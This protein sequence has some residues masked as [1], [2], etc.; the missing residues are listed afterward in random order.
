MAFQAQQ[1]MVDILLCG[2]SRFIAV[3]V[4]LKIFSIVMYNYFFLDNVELL[5]AYVMDKFSFRS[6]SPL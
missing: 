1:T 2:I 6:R 5:S 3:T 4:F